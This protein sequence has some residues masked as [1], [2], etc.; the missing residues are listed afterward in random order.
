MRSVSWHLAQANVA[1]LRAPIGSDLLADFVAALE[2]IN[3]L[4]D[5]S[6]GFLWR[7]QTEDG[8]STAI[9]VFDDERIIINMSVWESLEQ[10]AHFVYDTAHLEVMRGRRR[11]FERMAESHMVLWWVPAGS[12]PTAEAARDRL[13]ELR[14]NGQSDRAFTF[15]TP[16]AAP[17]SIERSVIDERWGCPTA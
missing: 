9:R 14:E 12:R 13:T 7:L 6:P 11:W 8:Y 1:I 4:A 3:A 2:P 15:K 17:G 10:L 16:F 5:A